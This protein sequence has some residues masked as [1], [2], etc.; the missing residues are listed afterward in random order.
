MPH[1]HLVRCFR[2]VAVVVAILED[3]ALKLSSVINLDTSLLQAAHSI[4]SSL[5]GQHSA[6]LGGLV[7]RAD[8][9]RRIPQSGSPPLTSH[10]HSV[11]AYEK[12]L[13]PLFRG[14]QKQRRASGTKRQIPA[15]SDFTFPG[16]H[17]GC[18]LAETKA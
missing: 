5:V 3:S 14:E 2:G 17:C 9:I 7:S 10:Q 12:L 13:L 6:G 18:K 16:G 4:A 8:K 1:R 15:H 11:K